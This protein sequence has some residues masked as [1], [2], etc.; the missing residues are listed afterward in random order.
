MMK[1]REEIRNLAIIAHVDHGKTTLV[2]AMLHQ[3]GLFRDNETVAERMMDRLD[4]EREKG[5]TI[6]SKNT[7]IQYKGI[8][9][10]ILDTPGHADFGGEVQRV[11]KMVDGCL[12]LVD[13]SEGPLPQTRYVLSNALAHGLSPVVVINKIDRPDARIEEVQDEI[14][15]LFL[16]L[17]ASEEQC[18]FPIIYTIAKDGMATLNHEQPGT[19]LRPLFEMILEHVPS[20]E[21]EEDHPLQV[22]ITT[23]DY[24]DYLGRIGI[25]RIS[26]GII[27]VGQR[28]LMTDGRKGSVPRQAK[29]SQLFG[30]SGLKRNPI[31]TAGPG[32]II[33]IAGI[34]GI[35]LGDTLTDTEEP[36][37]L[38][39]LKI[40]EP[41]LEMIFSVN[42]SPMAGLEGK[43]VTS[44]QIR[45]RLFKEIQGNPSLQ[46]EETDS[47]D[48]FKVIGRGELQF[49]ILLETMRREGFEVSV[50]KP[51][52]R[53]IREDG[54]L[55]EPYEIVMIDCPEEYIGVITQ[56]MGMR[57][58]K[59][60]RMVN[61]DSGWVR[62]EFEI[63]MR[64]L[65]G[66]RS[67][68]I[69]ETRGTAILNHIFLGW[70]EYSGD[71]P[72]RVNG[73]LI[74]DRPGKATGYALENLQ[75]RGK[76]FIAPGD[77]MYSGRVVG[78]NSRSDDM[79]VNPTKEKK[80]TNMRAAGS[81]DAYHLHP[82][83]IITLESALEFIEEDE[84]VEVT[85]Q[86]IRLRK[87][88]LTQEDT[89]KAYRQA[90]T[91]Q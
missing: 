44:R 58:A 51:R 80:L 86:S 87:R 4:L 43:L 28:V 18:N 6:M 22:Q 8:T 62:L 74:A 11:L 50:S 46:V 54:K 75:E 79:W 65:L 10:N 7:S 16:D 90:M 19:D 85:P 42:T 29:I 27:Q 68:L 41:S 13:A 55:L 14:L 81:D 89:R 2:D 37:P 59:M 47:K 15:E 67:L 73:V 25:G 39:P 91:S 61:N 66:L 53:T 21:Y 35:A 9:I 31:E 5:I 30:F 83:K 70:F 17:D 32:E 71:I 34:D 77:V 40:D 49:A 88:H 64:G 38:P 20:P 82:P 1:K 36:R 63:P 69:V 23:L 57:R 78:A 76:M 12:L 33:A 48:S 60:K 26:N 56:T 52:V 24:S 45:E 72:R 84:L 3:S